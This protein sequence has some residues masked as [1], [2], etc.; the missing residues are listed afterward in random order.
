MP[1]GRVPRH[2]T[3]KNT[4]ACFSAVGQ[5]WCHRSSAQPGCPASA[6]TSLHEVLTVGLSVRCF[7]PVSLII[8]DV[9]HDLLKVDVR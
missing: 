3:H 4:A 5:V 9:Q 7:F 6:V 2:E 1:R 8:S